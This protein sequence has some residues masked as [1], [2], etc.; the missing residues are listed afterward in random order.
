[1]K[2]RVS[3]ILATLLICTSVFSQEVMAFGL[4]D[5]SELGKL[6]SEAASGIADAAGTAGGAIA[7]AAGTAGG[8]I[9]DTAG[10]AGG[11][12]VDA[13]GQVGEAAS[14]IAGNVGD[15]VSSAAGQVSD[16]VSGF[17]SRAGEVLS[18]WGAVA[19]ETADSVKQ[20]LSD[21]GV[22]VKTSAEELG[23]ATAK[24]ASKLTE[25]AGKTADDAIGA[26]TDAG[27]FVVDRAGHVIDLAAAAAD[28]V[29]SEAAEALQ[30][31]QRYGTLLMN[32]AEAAVSGIDLSKEESW[33]EAKAAV[34][35][36]VDKAFDEGIIDREKVSEEA[37]QI[38]TRIVFGALMYGY[39]YKN[40][41]ITLGD[42]V[43]AMSEVLIREGLPT[44]VGFLVSIL[45]I[46]KIPH[47]ESLAKEATIYLISK[48]YGDE[49]GNEIEAEEEALLEDYAGRG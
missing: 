32:L 41:Q 1:M 15:V 31:L 35:A 19:G 30:V 24:K 9:A 3:A 47:A 8:A 18:G 26:V 17:A 21:A 44:G 36:A 27:G 33:E 37:I 29:S 20:K 6:A 43:S 38:A 48:A 7:D 39:Q 13:A 12:I 11:A 28:Y 4:P 23:S 34:D 46:N 40:E 25:Q 22:K 49:P 2:K 14:D 45:P 16:V 42:Y 10:T 5:P